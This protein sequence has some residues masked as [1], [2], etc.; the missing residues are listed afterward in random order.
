ME[1][2]A[3]IFEAK[4]VPEGKNL[5]IEGYAAVF[6]NV[7]T[8]NDIL[9]PG[10]CQKSIT[11]PGAS[12]I[13]LCT[14]HKQT[15]II[16]VVGKVLELREDAKGL[17]FR[18]KVSNTSKGRDAAELILDEA[19]DEISVGFITKDFY[20]QR[21]TRYLKEIDVRE[22]SIV[23]RAANVEAR[24][25]SIEIKE[26]QEKEP[27]LEK[28][29]EPDYENMPNDDLI[30]MRQKINTEITKRTLKKI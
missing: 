17:W 23:I 19:I 16:D 27:E 24:I 4:A 3:Q 28:P 30:R 6:G 26:E 15:D 18:A 13:K 11:G 8:Y 25:G 5:Y 14:Q 21:D 1:Y 29:K 10:S 2:K 12:R 22:I 20:M 9:L 7:D